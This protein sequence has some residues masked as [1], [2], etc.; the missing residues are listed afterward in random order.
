[1]EERA[2]EASA[3]LKAISNETRLMLLCALIDGEQSVGALEKHL[4]TRQATVSQHLARLKQDGLVQARRDG[5]T[6]YY[7]IADAYAVDIMRV[8]FAKFCGVKS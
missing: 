4:N 7:S 5:K 1:M 6:I 2:G 3:F 8:L